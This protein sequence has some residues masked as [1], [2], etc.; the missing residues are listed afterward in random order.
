MAEYG[1]ICG[2]R[3]LNMLEW[4]TE[5]MGVIWLGQNEV[6]EK[7]IAWGIEEHLLVLTNRLDNYGLAAAMAADAILII[8][9]DEPS[10]VACGRSRWN[11]SM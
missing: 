7:K 8:F 11:L 5:I 10:C 6:D 2:W 9:A 3:D 1:K 4:V